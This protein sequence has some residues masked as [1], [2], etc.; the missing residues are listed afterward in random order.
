MSTNIHA[1]AGSDVHI[2]HHDLSPRGNLIHRSHVSSG[3]LRVYIDPT[4][5]LQ[6]Y[7]A[8]ERHVHSDFPNI[9][10]RPTLCSHSYLLFSLTAG[11]RLAVTLHSILVKWR[12][13]LLSIK[14][15][16]AL[17]SSQQKKSMRV[18]QFQLLANQQQYIHT[19]WLQVSRR[20]RGPRKS[21]FQ[22]TSADR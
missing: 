21:P 17:Y 11:Y 3:I 12:M 1:V 18:A 10:H 16:N 9:R 20:L 7:F 4:K 19:L 15:N 5:A 2:E 13:R 8:F 14:L 22:Q 6:P